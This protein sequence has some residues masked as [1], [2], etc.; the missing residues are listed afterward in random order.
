MQGEVVVSVCVVT[1]NQEQY[2]GQC[3]ES[4]VNQKTSF[5]FELIVGEDFS[6]DN[7]AKIVQKIAA[8]YPE[9]VIPIVRSENIG[10][11]K[12]FM[13]VFERA[14]GDFIAYC[15]GDDY[16]IDENKL[17]KQYDAL[18]RHPNVDLCFHP[19]KEYRNE[20][21]HSIIN[22]YFNEETIIPFEKVVEGRGGFMPSNSLF[23]RSSSILPFPDWFIEKVPVGD[24]FIQALAAKKG[25][26]YY[27]PNAMS[28]YRRFTLGS[29]TS[30][31]RVPTFEREK[32]VNII[33]AY[34][35]CYS[36]LGRSAAINKALSASV[37]ESLNKLVLV[38]D[39]EFVAKVYKA[40]R[41]HLGLHV[42]QRILDLVVKS[43]W[44]TRLYKRLIIIKRLR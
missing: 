19:A 42:K 23:I 25:G 39:H 11:H 3:L 34:V 40:Y 13:G 2:I 8:K 33:D 17:Q 36:C 44:L 29:M 24:T 35:Y 14:R 43:R 37:F 5:R 18:K 21:F 26:A 16:W 9:V 41:Q 6:P 22:N 15:E 27:L 28:I 38:A 20:K 31:G 1:Y 7:T 10:G 12:N 4:I 32:M 30:E